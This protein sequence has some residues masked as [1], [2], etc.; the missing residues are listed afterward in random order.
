MYKRQ[1]LDQMEA[2]V[3]RGVNKSPD[4]Y[5]NPD[6]LRSNMDQAYFTEMVQKAKNHIYEGDIFQVVLSQRFETDM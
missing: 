1:S 4:F 3:N 6:H 5:I 2:K